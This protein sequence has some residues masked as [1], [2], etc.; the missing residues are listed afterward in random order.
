MSFKAFLEKPYAYNLAISRSCDKL[1]KALERSAKSI[2]ACNPI[3]RACV[4]FSA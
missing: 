2:P 3:S 1:S 4:I